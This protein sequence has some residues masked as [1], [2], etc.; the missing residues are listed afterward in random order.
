MDKIEKIKLQLQT[1]FEF[2]DLELKLWKENESAADKKEIRTILKSDDTIMSCQLYQDNCFLMAKVINCK[3]SIKTLITNRSGIFQIFVLSLNGRTRTFRVYSSM[4]VSTLKAL[5]EQVGGIRPDQQRL[6]YGGKQLEDE[7][8]LADY[9]IEK[10]AT[11][12]LILRLRGGMYHFTSGRQDFNNLPYDGVQAIQ[13][14]LAFQIKPIN[15]IYFLSSTEL[16][17]FVLQAQRIL[18]NLSN[19]IGEKLVL[20]NHPK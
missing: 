12:H 6:L 20:D 11:I 18:S 16:Q 10:E 2:T 15:Q 5:I 1:C 19:T 13:N 7:R 9:K 4:K 14:A 3:I 17:D 8:I